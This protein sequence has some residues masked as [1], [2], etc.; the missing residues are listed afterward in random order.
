MLDRAAGR[1]YVQTMHAATK[2]MRV[3]I[4]IM[5]PEL[6]K[7]L[8][9]YDGSI[10][11]SPRGGAFT[12]YDDIISEISAGK[13]LPMPWS[14]NPTTA[15]IAANWYHLWPVGGHP[16]AGALYTGTA[17]NHQRTND[18]TVGSD[19]HGG[20]KSPDTKHILSL[21][22]LASA[23]A[24]PPMVLVVDQIGYYPL[25]QSASSQNFVNTNGPDRY[26]AAGEG[27]LQASLVNG[28]AGGA[29]A[30]NITVLTYVDQDGNA[31]NTM[32]TTTAVA[33]TV[34]TALPT[35]TLGARVLT[36]VAGPFIPL[37]VSD[38]GIRSLTNVTFSAANTGLEAFVM[39]RPLAFMPLRTALVAEERD[40]VQDLVSM[41]RVFDGACIAFMAFFPVATGCVFTGIINVAW[42]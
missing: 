21:M 14:K 29:T 24:T 39:L 12:T 33:V 35:A 25:T 16:Q 10:L 17:L 19:W 9:A 28:A 38:A 11:L 5:H 20:N 22:A 37:A 7:G 40:L 1:E 18:T 26:I 8:V 42:G 34:S 3:A 41:P 2:G 15:P 6:P 23:G 13:I 36:T 32:P 27:G 30:S 31:G 4:P